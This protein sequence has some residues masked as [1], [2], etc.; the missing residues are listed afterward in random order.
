MSAGLTRPET[1]HKKCF[2]MIRLILKHD[3][4]FKKVVALRLLRHQMALQI[5]L[6]KYHTPIHAEEYL[7]CYLCHE[8]PRDGPQWSWNSPKRIRQYEAV[9]K[10]C[11]EKPT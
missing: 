5:D 10:P 1:L 3:N 11:S 8:T 4:F 6:L 2:D 7:N 9:L